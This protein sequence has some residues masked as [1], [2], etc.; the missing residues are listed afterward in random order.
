MTLE[1]SHKS[2]SSK[3]PLI[4]VVIAVA[5]IFF[6][7][8]LKSK[9]DNL[10]TTTRPDPDKFAIKTVTVN[11]P[12]NITEQQAQSR[13]LQH[14]FYQDGRTAGRSADEL[15]LSFDAPVDIIGILM[16]VDCWKSTRLV[17][18]AAGI[19]QKPA[20]SINADNVLF[21][22]SFATNDTAGKIDE[23]IFFPT[24]YE[25]KV[26][27]TLNFGAWIQNVSS[28]PQSVSPEFIVYYKWKK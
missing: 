17:E 10:R 18:F 16:S 8:G 9:Y 15:S 4:L 24:P 28:K 14:L 5:L 7:P 1:F 6:V 22:V 20:Y 26:G 25:M 23:H 27:D 11:K 2:R 19:N 13:I 21:H 3:L 12:Q